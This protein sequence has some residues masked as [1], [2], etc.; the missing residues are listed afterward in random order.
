T[1]FFQRPLLQ[2]CRAMSLKGGPS[3]TYLATLTREELIN[4]VQQLEAQVVQLR[5]LVSPAGVVDVSEA[6][7]E[8]LQLMLPQPGKGRRRQR[9]GRVDFNQF[10]QRRVALRIAYMGWA[11]DGS[12]L[13]CLAL[14]L[15]KGV[16][17]LANV[18]SLN[19]RS[20]LS[21]CNTGCIPDTGPDIGKRRTPP[22]SED[23]EANELDPVGPLNR[24][25]PREL[26]V[27]AWAPVTP[28]FSARFACKG[29]EYLYHFP[30]ST[31]NIE[32]MRDACKRFVGEH[33]FRNFSKFSPDQANYCRTV[34]ECDIEPVDYCSQASD[35]NQM[36]AFRVR[37]TAFLYHQIRNMFSVLA[38]VGQGLEEPSIVD[39][40]LDVNATPRKPEYVLANGLPLILSKAEFD[41]LD[42][43]CSADAR[44]HLSVT[45]QRHWTELTVRSCLARLAVDLLPF[46]PPTLNWSH[47]ST[48]LLPELRCRQ[49]RPL[50]KRQLQASFEEMR[51][52]ADSKRQ[53]K[54][55]A[56]TGDGD[57]VQDE[58][59]PRQYIKIIS[60]NREKIL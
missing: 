14:E 2:A 60:Y 34:M 35:H 25:L 52:R 18:V 9:E 33:D 46:T 15:T 45:L 38:L 36:F 11:F 29:R 8:K 56:A 49:H 24:V 13:Q 7:E 3:A 55:L 57:V 53:L 32:A 41:H 30:R 44:E 42:W 20:L 6:G 48:G 23:T 21:D 39:K 19:I 10:K 31:F 59:R 51:E 4:R 26:R 54:Q 22:S 40:L 1:N 58:K 27:L 43:R 16:S 50:L 12:A 47:L 28:D 37:A 5:P 17:A